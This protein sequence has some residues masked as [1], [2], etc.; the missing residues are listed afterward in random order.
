MSTFGFTTDHQPTWCPGCGDFGIWTSVKNAMNAMELG[1][2]DVFFAYG[3]G[4]HGNMYNW[5]KTYGFA[6]LHGRSLPVAQGVKLAHHTMPVLCITG[7]GDCIGEGGNHFIHAAKRNAD[8]TV[9]LFDN[10]VYGLTT[11]Q[12]SPTARPGLKTKSTP[13]GVVDMPLSPAAL[14]IT[15]GATFVARGFAGDGKGLSDLIVKAVRHKGFSLVDILQP[16]VTFNK[17]FGYPWYREHIYDL[18]STGYMPDNRVKAFDK[19]MEWGEKLPV[20]VFFE[21]ERPAHTDQYEML[22]KDILVK[23]PVV[24]DVESMLHEFI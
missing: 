8:I 12:A 3:I 21:E 9:L 11:G 10:Q 23:Q 20:G 6:G 17:D 16:C 5:M 22:K 2:D 15:A 19:A 13:H 24:V 4:C 7:D 1:P 14:A 18:N